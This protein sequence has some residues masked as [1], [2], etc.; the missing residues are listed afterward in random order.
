MYNVGV[1][2]GK[3]FPP[4]RGHINAIIQAATKV[5]KLYVVVS[6]NTERANRICED[7]HIRK[8]PLIERARW[9]S[10]EVGDFE[11]IIVK[12]I[13]ETDIPEY[14]EGTKQWTKLL[15]K[16][17]PEKFDVIFGGEQEYR[18]TYMSNFSK[19]IDYVVYDY[20]RD[21]YPISGTIIR[22]NPIKYWDYILGSARPHFAKRVLI[23]GVE[24][25]GKTTI[26]KYL[27]KIY[28]TSW[29][30]EYGRFYAEE[31]IGGNEDFFNDDDFFKIAS[32]QVDIDEEALNNA[33]KVVFFDTDAVVTQF[34]AE[35]YL[36]HKVK[37][38]DQ[39]IDKEKYDLILLMGPDVPW[40][41]DGQRVNEDL[42][43][44]EA[45]FSELK[46]MYYSYGF[47]EHASIQEI[48]FDNYSDRLTQSMYYIDNLLKSDI[49]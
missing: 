43:V 31:K 4:H 13:D 6:D 44:R 15:I 8:M 17:I 12:M 11:H 32:K 23:T 34:Y 25:A 5:K 26:T 42:S 28:H 9:I 7:T 27:G 19:E 2:P 1:F 41:A 46:K 38:V 18:K 24:S 16:A 10:R 36:G 35:M 40:V 30:Q 45:L 39:F 14:P 37:R 33:N 21:R 49:L 47:Y 48:R 29:T 22:E 3:F 20:K